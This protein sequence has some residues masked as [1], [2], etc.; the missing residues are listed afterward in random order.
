MDSETYKSIRDD[1]TKDPNPVY[2]FFW[3]LRGK[4][5][6]SS[7]QFFQAFWLWILNRVG[8]HNL[9][10]IENYVFTELNKHYGKG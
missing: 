2:Y 8:M 5:S 3:Q 9:P 1:Q 7:E 10:I 6:L 4:T